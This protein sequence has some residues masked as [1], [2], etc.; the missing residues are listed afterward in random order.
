MP[1]TYKVK[2]K[3]KPKKYVQQT[4]FGMPS[5]SKL[6]SSPPSPPRKRKRI[7]TPSSSGDSD[8]DEVQARKTRLKHGALSSSD[9]SEPYLGSPKKQTQKNRRIDSADENSDSGNS[10]Q[11]D[12]SVQIISKKPVND[13][14]KRKAQ[15]Q[16]ISESESDV[17]L[18]SKPRRLVKQRPPSVIS[19]SDEIASDEVDSESEHLK[20]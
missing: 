18:P 1:P 4:L 5:S 20:F 10:M 2:A 9:D 15:K 17:P 11:S 16:H 13:K 14:G 19:D 3:T 7:P 8:S 6:H 12:A